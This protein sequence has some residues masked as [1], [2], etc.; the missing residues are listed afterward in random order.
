MLDNS[1]KEFVHICWKT[2]NLF[3]WRDTVLEQLIATTTAANISF[4][5]PYWPFLIMVVEKLQRQGLFWFY[6]ISLI[7]SIKIGN[8]LIM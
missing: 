1:I 6:V 8:L 5:G 2:T 3:L 7:L 4:Q